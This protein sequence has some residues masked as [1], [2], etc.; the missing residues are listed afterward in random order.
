QK[1]AGIIE[2]NVWGHIEAGRDA[3][4]Q[5]DH[6]K[7][8]QSFAEAIRQAERLGVDGERVSADSLLALALL[9]VNQNRYA[10]AEH[11][12][13]RALTILGSRPGDALKASVLFALGSVLH[14]EGED[15]QAEAFLQRSLTIQDS[16][17]S[18]QHRRVVT[19]I[20]L[21][22]VAHALGKYAQAEQTYLRVLSIRERTLETESPELIETL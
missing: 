4:R 17:G 20:A 10:E 3:E 12:L 19:L 18:P 13:R 2:G 1:A 5:G 22:R 9:H 14:R 15:A 21:A 7:A 16:I 11:L 8:E 6:A